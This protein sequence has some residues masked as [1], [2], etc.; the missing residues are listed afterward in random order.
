MSFRLLVVCCMAVLALGYSAY[1]LL[2]YG[3]MSGILAFAACL[4]VCLM[5]AV[6][7]RPRR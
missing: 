5:T 1:T 2:A 7:Q 3:L 4:V 6:L